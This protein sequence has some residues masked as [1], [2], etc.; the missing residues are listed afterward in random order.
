VDWYGRL[1]SGGGGATA[2]HRG[3]MGTPAVSPVR[4]TTHGSTGPRRENKAAA[5]GG[6]TRWSSSARVAS[7]W[8]APALDFVLHFGSVYGS[9]EGSL[10]TKWPQAGAAA[11]S[12]ARRV[13][14]FARDMV[15]LELKSGLG[16]LA[17]GWKSQ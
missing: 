10:A 9:S 12:R 4:A 15:E 11:S 7:R 6:L 1:E 17:C 3:T 16:F 5:H 13:L 14:R 8:L 2:H